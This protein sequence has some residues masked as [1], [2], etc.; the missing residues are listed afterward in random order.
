VSS[1]AGKLRAEIATADK[2]LAEL[3]AQACKLAPQQRDLVEHQIT[4]AKATVRDMRIKL[5][6]L[7]DRKSACPVCDGVTPPGWLV[8]E[9]CSGET[10]AKLHNAWQCASHHAHAR[11]SNSYPAADIALAEGN[12]QRAALAVISHLKQHGSALTALTFL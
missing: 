7:E 3:E 2:R 4:R 8:C 12:E 1:E 10:P 11:R 5:A 6:S 9:A